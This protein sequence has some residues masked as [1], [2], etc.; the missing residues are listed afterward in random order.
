MKKETKEKHTKIANDIMYYIYKN[1]NTDINID[2]LS[3]DMNIS[4]FHMQ[5]IFKKEFDENIYE[6]IKSIRLQ[7]AS[8]LLLTN[9]YSTITEIAKMCGYSSQGAFI[10]VFKEKFKM[11]PKEWKKG[12]YINFSNNILKSSV[13]GSKSTANFSELIPKIIKIN[14]FKIYYIRHKGYNQSIKNIWQKLQT[15]S[16][17]N[18]IKSSKQ[19][20]VHHDNPTITPLVDCKYIGG[21]AF[22]EEIKNS[23]LPYL[24]IPEEIYAKFEFSGKYG[25]IIAFM[26]WIYFDW[27]INNDYETTT[28][29]SFV[30][31]NKNHFLE[32]DETFNVQYH[33][34]IKY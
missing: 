7:K 5:R 22:D 29:P 31:Y 10:R 3:F 1:I 33:I 12:G 14:S 16:L 15:W 18:N 13:R 27:I 20:G 28:N 23:S 9:K 17:C 6:S 11:T 32:E 24:Q 34:P 30:I 26:N 4:R 21:I 19:I 2:E 8:N 25:D